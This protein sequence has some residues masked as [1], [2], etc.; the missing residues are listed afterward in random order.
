[1]TQPHFPSGYVRAVLGGRDPVA[2][3]ILRSS[4]GEHAQPTIQVDDNAARLLELLVRVARPERVLEIGTLFGYSTL[5]L[6]RGLAGTGTVTSIEVDPAAARLARD[7]LDAAGLA[8]R[9]SILVGDAV[10]V[11]ATLPEDPF[12]FVFVDGRK[13]EYPRY[14]AA[15]HPRLRVGGLLVADDAFSAGDF[16]PD[17]DDDTDAARGISGYV[18]ALGRSSSYASA[19][20]GTETGLLISRKESA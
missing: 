7:N 12:D 15:V 18:R 6:A 13:S 5:H 1:M 19:F 10:E 16:A 9:V 20:A 14:L 8:D 17:G 2:D 3:S 11:L 4:L